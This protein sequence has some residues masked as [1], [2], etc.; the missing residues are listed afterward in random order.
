[1]SIHRNRPK[2]RAVLA[3]AITAVVAFACSLDRE[4][5]PSAPSALQI[6]SSGS[7]D[8]EN[9]SDF[10]SQP[11][12]R[13]TDKS[14]KFVMKPGVAVVASLVKSGGRLEGDTLVLTGD[15]GAVV[16]KHLRAVG[17]IGAGRIEFN[18]DGLEAA[19]YAVSVHAGPPT[20]IS[21]SPDTLHGI[22]DHR[23]LSL[24][25]AKITDDDANPVSGAKVAV[26]ALG[27]GAVADTLL[28][29][30]TLGFAKPQS[31]VL[32]KSAGL[33]RLRFEIVTGSSAIVNAVAEAGDAASIR[34]LS[35]LAD[36][37]SQGEPLPVQPRFEILDGYGNRVV[38]AGIVI[39]ARVIE[40]GGTTIG[41]DSVATNLEGVAEFIGLGVS[42]KASEKTLE[43][44]AA[45]MVGFSA[46]LI[47]TPGRP[48]ALQLVSLPSTARSAVVIDSQFTVQLVD[49]AGNAVPASGNKVSLAVPNQGATLTGADTSLTD[50][51]GVA[52]FGGLRLR[53][54]AGPLKLIFN[55]VGLDSLIATVR[56]VAGVPARVSYQASDSL[57]AAPGAKVSFASGLAVVDDDDNPVE[58]ANIAF[59]V[60][61]GGGTIADTSSTTDSTGVAVIPSWTIGRRPGVNTLR[62]RVE[63]S[64]AAT[65]ITATSDLSLAVPASVRIT[66]L[67][68]DSVI[69]LGNSIALAARALDSVGNVLTGHKVTWTS[70]NPG[71][72]SI[73]DEGGVG[74]IGIGATVLR[75]TIAG[76][77]DSQPVSV[78]QPLAVSAS[79]GTVQAAGGSVALQVAQGTIGDTTLNVAPSARTPAA[80]LPGTAF[81]FGPSGT[82]FSRPVSLTLKYDAALVAADQ[83]QQLRIVQARGDTLIDLGASTVDTLAHTV[84]TKITHFSTYA[85][86]DPARPSPFRLPLAVSR[87]NVTF[88]GRIGGTVPP[89]QCVTLAGPGPF[90]V[91]PSD[92]RIKYSL[93]QGPLVS[94]L[95]LRFDGSLT[96]DLPATATV[97]VRTQNHVFDDTRIIGVNIEAVTSLPA[98]ATADVELHGTC[99]SKSVSLVSPY[100]PV[101]P[102]GS[103]W[104]L[105]HGRN[106]DP[107]ASNM[108][109]L[110]QLIRNRDPQ[111]Q[112][113]LLDWREPADGPLL[114]D[115]ESWILD[116]GTWA[117]KT[118]QEFGFAIENLNIVGHSWGTYVG[119]TL[120]K[121]LGGKAR[122]FV[123]LDPAANDP[124]GTDFDPNLPEAGIN[125]K[126]RASVS[127]AFHSSCTLGSE[128]TSSTALHRFNVVT[129]PGLAMDALKHHSLATHVLMALLDNSTSGKRDIS[130]ALAI[131]KIASGTPVRW[132]SGGGYTSDCFPAGTYDGELLALPSGLPIELKFRDGSLD[133]QLLHEAPYLAVTAVQPSAVFAEATAQSMRID[134]AAFGEDASIVLYPPGGG[135]T[136][137]VPPSSI[138]VASDTRI[139]FQ[140]SFAGEPSGRWE[141]EVHSLGAISRRLSFLVSGP[142]GIGSISSVLLTAEGVS[143]PASGIKQVLTGVTS[144]TQ[145]N[146]NPATFVNLPVGSYSV[147]GYITRYKEWGEELWGDEK[148]FVLNAQGDPV[149]IRR[150][151]PYVE[152]TSLT[153]TLT[154]GAISTGGLSAIG[155]PLSLALVVRND[156]AVAQ[157]VT[158][159]LAMGTSRSSSTRQISGNSSAVFDFPVTPVNPGPV[160]Y[161]AMVSTR[162]SGSDQTTD[163]RDWTRLVTAV[164]GLSLSSSSCTIG[165]GESTCTIAA[166]WA[167]SNPVGTSAVTSDTPGPDSQ[168]A[169][170]NTGAN[171][172][173]TVFFGGRTFYLYNNA[174][175]LDR[176]TVTASC[177]AG[178]RWDGTVCTP[179]PSGLLTLTG[180]SCVIAAGAS[181]CAVSAT[182]TTENPV[183]VS[184]IT[185]DTPSADTQIATGN[186]GAD[187]ALTVF[188]GG[189]NFF[190]YNDQ[191][192]LDRKSVTA[193][194]TSGTAWSGTQCTTIPP[195]G[196]LSL[197]P[198]SCAIPVGSSNCTINATW[199][200]ANPIGTSAVT[201]DSPASHTQ[202]ATGNNGSAVPLT[203]PF[204]GRTFYL[205]N[206][207]QELDR[208]TV[209][210]ACVTGGAWNGSA[211]APAPAG[212]LTLSAN[213]CSIPAGASTCT[214]NAT[215]TTSN[216]LGTSAITSDTP[217]PN[218]QIISANSGTD[219][220]LTVF[221]G[222]RTF[223]LYNNQSEL[224][225]HAVTAT[226]AAGTSWDGATCAV[227]PPSGVLTLASASCEIA[228]DAST[229]SINA[230]WTTENPVGTSAI[231]SDTPI[232]NTQVA[233]GNNGVVVPLAVTFGGRTFFLFNNARELDR[234]RV[235]AD[236]ATGTAWN[237][238]ACHV[239]PPTGSLTLSS[240]SCAIA[241]GA[242]SCVVR[243]TWVTN[244]PSG[245]SAITSDLPTVNTTVTTGNS[246][247]D[248]AIPV[249]FG[250]RTFFLYNNQQELD[251]KTAT[252]SCLSGSVWNGSACATPPSGTLTLSSSSCTIAL[253][254]STCNVSAS[255]VTSN[256]IGT[257]AITS[258]LPAANTAVASGNT[259][260]MSFTIFHG[261]RTFFLYNNELEL[262]RKNVDA[263][264]TAGSVWS[265]SVC[266]KPPAGTLTLASS[267][268]TIAVGASSCSVNASWTTTNPIGTSAITSD[269]PNSNAQITTGNSATNFSLVVTFS[270][271]TFYLYNN[272]QELDRKT[273]TAACAS[274]ST[275]DGSS[276][277]KPSGNLTLS[278]SSCTIALNASSCSVKATW[279]TNNPIGTSALTSDTPSANTQITTGNSGNGFTVAVFF[280]SRNFYLYNN[281]LQLDQGTATASCVIGSGWN[282]SACAKTTGSLALAASSCTIA[283]NA[284]T[285]TVNATWSTSNPTG[286]SAITS[287]TP[288]L[289]T[290]LAT[291]NSGS[292]ALT[293]L[294]G[295]RTFYLYNNQTELDHKV[296]TSS[297]VTGAAW[298]G[299]ACVVTTG[300]L[301]MASSCTIA[302]G[303]SSCSVVG[304]WSTT[305][306]IGTSAITSSTPAN[307]TILATAN[308][309]TNVSFQVFFG[310]RS[311]FLYNNQKEL[312]AKTV[313]AS[314]A[315]GSTW[316]GSSCK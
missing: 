269:T 70:S 292:K 235:V 291:G 159:S 279:N 203:V 45:G 46:R 39:R 147:S 287:D 148:A 8:V 9:R 303:A 113:L 83:V 127:I 86:P 285:C 244:N 260:S 144:R 63:G 41:A 239:I 49:G 77:L 280:G 305:N 220:P 296:A 72:A 289:N 82:T 133:E 149:Q 84:S 90:E 142:S 253:G 231:T 219:A 195:S 221:F 107:T 47:V 60:D 146:V 14:G 122:I 13:I 210:A 1:M 26:A 4:T 150:S 21:V 189:R 247:S 304:S 85:I 103:T 212:T 230:S 32:S 271:R 172:P 125:F 254:A 2:T 300:S 233:T 118:L 59:A 316:N 6:I 294:F 153:S 120:A 315:S 238:T 198:S 64:N 52:H 313:S 229:C 31:W 240:T 124:S 312:A 227:V 302:R 152:S 295:G 180:S 5:G 12:V 19:S 282:G 17:S 170:G 202:V 145:S 284:A 135:S 176:R 128:I 297:C 106:S 310:G 257:S 28:Y 35:V 69:L 181:T 23:L 277:A 191:R 20:Q 243:A 54:K 224:D 11:I 27:G 223:Y 129:P 131:D 108:D 225:R 241:L 204:G 307:N 81:D 256:P 209:T 18:A 168:V 56:L 36:S 174:Q 119:H 155:T 211:C 80:T 102:A 96:N 281:Q 57:K 184:A 186:A 112:I 79:G 249:F 136:V 206:N 151:Y 187:L 311:F 251:R 123:A 161:S 160:E 272:Q 167:T 117:A 173:F 250:S 134:G 94:Q 222:G 262:D 110:G 309:G 276:C 178:T 278:S 270:S 162:I 192:E 182:W 121:T 166:S 232:P 164:P 194:C 267:A 175:E 116:V 100:G 185:S 42:G 245:T 171:V 89:N 268:C 7:A 273:A 213:D 158:V 236:C 140:H 207:E 44:T 138:T 30:D 51:L 156:R 92:S 157:T 109:A 65:S 246:G 137:T 98:D 288:A 101:V 24:P 74:A 126:E 193:T 75:A 62:A 205:Y 15:D 197:V 293:V 261:G 29:A 154:G 252:G 34:M 114:S 208:K 68:P 258:D 196:T 283:A 38:R 105:I 306:P 274:G 248:L 259:G 200:T 43:F 299:S 66:D 165:A 22:V 67:P 314:C 139:D 290:Q 226:C 104:I 61:S 91:V 33:N 71:V 286:T 298:N 10:D 177:I 242:S 228:A 50:G 53:G 73:S 183:G 99:E 143:S 234:V 301:T 237:G 111:A 141:L 25:V 132:Q 263:N 130:S 188:F 169:V 87:D 215:W 264:C 199:N 55:A 308:S 40:G 78:R 3:A 255:W 93:A 265:G 88:F 217:S 190:L 115:G 95:R 37:A 216:P 275:W 97:T 76:V 58:G 218:T 214:I 179:I 16:F 163:V 266:A 48:Q 201:S